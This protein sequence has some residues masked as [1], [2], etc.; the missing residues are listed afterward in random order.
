TTATSPGEASSMRARTAASRRDHRPPPGSA[1]TPGAATVGD[2]RAAGTPGDGSRPTQ[3]ART[4]RTDRKGNRSKE[5]APERSGSEDAP[6]P[7]GRPAAQT[8][9]GDGA[10]RKPPARRDGP[11]PSKMPPRPRQRQAPRGRGVRAVRTVPRRPSLP[12]QVGPVIFN[13]LDG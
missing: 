12:P 5:N 7:R 9:P 8:G 13:G 2:V 1:A 3:P 11:G 4:R 6:G 10:R